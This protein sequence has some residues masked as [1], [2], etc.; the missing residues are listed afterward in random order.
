MRSTYFEVIE[1]IPQSKNGHNAGDLIRI[2]ALIPVMYALVRFGHLPQ[3]NRAI[4]SSVKSVTQMTTKVGE[5]SRTAPSVSFTNH[6]GVGW[7]SSTLKEASESAR[8][9]VMS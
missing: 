9:T 3:K 2:P 7:F 8:M 6:G 5:Y 4:S 1:I